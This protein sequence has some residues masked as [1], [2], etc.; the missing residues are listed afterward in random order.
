IDA[1]INAIFYIEDA[2]A[3]K[4]Y[5]QINQVF[6]SENIKMS[7]PG[8]AKK[9]EKLL[10]QLK[11]VAFPNLDDNEC[12]DVLRN[13]YLES[14]D[15]EVPMEQR[16]IAKLFSTPFLLRDE[17]REK[18]KRALIENEQKI[19]DLTIR[20]WIQEFEKMYDVRNRSLSAS[21]DFV[22]SNNSARQLDASSQY[23]LKHLLHD[24]DY[25]LVTTLPAVGIELQQI[26]GGSPGEGEEEI[27]LSDIRSEKTFNVLSRESESGAESS[28]F[29]SKPF[30]E[31]LS[32]YPGLS[33]Q[34]IT[35]R[36]ISIQKSPQP[37]RPSIRNWLSDYTFNLGYTSHNSIER[38]NYLFQ[39]PNAKI[40]GPSDRERLSYI[41]KSYDEKTPVT[42]DVSRKQLIFPGQLEISKSDQNLSASNIDLRRSDL[43]KK[44]PSALEKNYDS[45][46][47]PEKRLPS[48]ENRPLSASSLPKSNSQLNKNV[49]SGIK[50]NPASHLGTSEFNINHQPTTPIGKMVFN[51]SQKFPF[52]KERETSS[53]PAGNI[54]LRENGHL[55]PSANRQFPQGKIQGTPISRSTAPEKDFS[56]DINQ[57][58]SGAQP[59]R[60]NPVTYN[61]GEDELP[62]NV[63]NLKDK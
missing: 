58:M 33:E 49:G 14:F 2:D 48:S 44:T 8:L 7:D 37:V 3:K 42:V 46:Q 23:K 24:Y 38:S 61:N 57:E 4:I 18:F 30:H 17:P 62:K 6:T 11:I 20:Q 60:I 45:Y 59:L 28:N 55:L 21:N 27:N 41:L 9:L 47:I 31:A 35:S 50:T 22:T 1:A 19:G 26:L 51:S 54:S 63:V 39:N 40:L 53:P 56:S 25:L 5:T 12:Q 52:E 43:T 16:L 36:L 32:G 10:I 13:H 34:L 15:I 29:I